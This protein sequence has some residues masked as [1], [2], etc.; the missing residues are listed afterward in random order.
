MIKN[1]EIRENTH[2][3]FHFQSK[4]FD[5]KEAVWFHN[6][7][8]FI[9]HSSVETSSIENFEK[10]CYQDQLIVLAKINPS[11]A[12]KYSKIALKREAEKC[13]SYKNF[14]VEYATTGEEMCVTCD[15]KIDRLEPRIKSIVYNSHTAELFGKEVIWAHMTCF[16]F[17]REQHNYPWDGKLL[18]GFENLQPED[19]VF[20][21]EN[22]P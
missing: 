11:A 6:N 9:K 3:F 7:C 12:D 10:L 8:F 5:G 17:S 19:Q 4:K 22:L 15:Q 1:G 21:A 18:E 14:G 2:N 16:A 20:I 13:S